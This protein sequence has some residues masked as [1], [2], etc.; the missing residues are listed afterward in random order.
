[1]LEKA[2][3]ERKIIIFN[4]AEGTVGEA[5]GSAFGRLIVALLKGI[6]VRRD[7]QNKRVST[8]VII[9]E[10]HNF[11][12]RSMEKII[13]QAAKFKLYLTMA[14]Q[15]IGQGTSKEIRDAILNVSVLIGGRNAPTF[16]GPVASMLNVSP[17][18]IGS[19]DRGDFIAHLSGS[20]PLPFHIHTH[21]LGSDAPHERAGVGEGQGRPAQ[22]VLQAH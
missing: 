9:D 5:E 11:T 4:L 17:E 20:P 3:E 2:I 18:D 19:L 22:A 12:T 8:R 15:Q 14:Q 6:A 13:T 21:L 16:H 1:M 10:F 7:R